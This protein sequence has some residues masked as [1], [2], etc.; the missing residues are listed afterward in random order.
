MARPQTHETEGLTDLHHG[1]RKRQQAIM[2]QIAT[3]Q[4]QVAKLLTE[5]DELRAELCG[6]APTQAIAWACQGQNR[7]EGAA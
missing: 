5:C 7:Q 3:K 6:V 4:I 2:R 1:I